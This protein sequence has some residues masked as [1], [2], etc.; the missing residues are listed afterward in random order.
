MKYNF[1]TNLYLVYFKSLGKA[2]LIF[3]EKTNNDH[4]LLVCDLTDIPVKCKD[5]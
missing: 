1:R 3:F 5:K 4:T 2:N